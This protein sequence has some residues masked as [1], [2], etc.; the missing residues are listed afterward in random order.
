M[1]ATAVTG[2]TRPASLVPYDAVLVL[3][4]GGPDTGDDVMPFLHDV[5][6][7]KGIPDERLAEVAGHYHRFGGRSPINAENRLLIAQ[8]RAEL[9]ARGVRIPVIFG[10]MHWHPRTL[11]ALR[12]A[13]AFG[14]HRVLAVITSA[15]ASYSGSR[16][17]REHLAAVSRALAA[18][19]SPL[20]LDVLRPYFNHPGFVDANA[21]AAR[22]ALDALPTGRRTRLVAVTHSIPDTM[23]RASGVTGPTYLQQHQEELRLIDADLRAHGH[24][25]VDS[26]LAFCS[27]S[28]AP[29][30]P[31]LE[32]D[33]SDSLCRARD[34]GVEQ[35]V[36]APIGFIMD[37]MEVVYDLDTEAL[38]TA[39]EIG[40]PAVRATTAIHRPE[41]IAGLADL[42]TERAARERG[43]DAP[44]TAVGRYEGFP[45]DAPAGSCLQVD[46]VE[47]GVPVIAGDE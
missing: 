18:E 3:S 46:G 47:S 44:R 5:T 10:N 23:N 1:T 36:I 35:V 40:L 34:A 32:P 7:G 27:R 43:E 33:V 16:Q 29:G 26:V 4:F 41:F 30:S 21:A 15:Y 8:L 24:E 28:G 13:V 6:A 9:S 14:A 22:A 38:A 37:H 25:D 19:G 17:Y 45:D 42:L 12:T 39:G 11:D 2:T 31:W 20:R